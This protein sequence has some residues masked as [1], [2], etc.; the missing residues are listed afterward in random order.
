MQKIKLK[1]VGRSKKKKGV[2]NLFDMCLSKKVF[3]K[4]RESAN[5]GNKRGQ[6]RGSSKNCGSSRTCWFAISR[7]Q[8]GSSYFGN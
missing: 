3:K 6:S 5:L 2:K 8:E 1:G 4:G 7:E